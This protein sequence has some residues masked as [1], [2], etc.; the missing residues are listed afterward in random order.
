MKKIITLLLVVVFVALVG[1][2][3]NIH[4]IGNGPQSNTVIEARQ[5]YALFGLV[6]IN[7]VDTAQ[8]AGDAKDYEIKTE[9]S[10]MDII[11]NIFTSYITVYSRTV[12][13]TK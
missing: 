3:T 2:S 13:V 11:M 9:Q 12:T 5:W 4:K 8:M 10:P 1:C 6:P 7:N